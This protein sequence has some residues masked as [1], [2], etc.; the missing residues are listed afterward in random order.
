MQDG[1]FGAASQ[2]WA[3]GSGPLVLPSP[4][5]GGSEDPLMGHAAADA[6]AAAAGAASGRTE[7]PRMGADAEATAVE[8][9]GN[10]SNGGS[11]TIRAEHL[12]HYS[13]DS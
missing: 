13:S 5:L 7:D 1:Y 4:T 8:A 10:G 3:T 11:S 6:G 2:G 9:Q 12:S